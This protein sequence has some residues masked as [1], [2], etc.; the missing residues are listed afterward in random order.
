MPVWGI[1]LIAVGGVFLL[2][3][4]IVGIIIDIVLHKFLKREDF[5]EPTALMSYK[6]VPFVM[7]RKKYSFRSGRNKIAAFDYGMGNRKG[8]VIYVHGMCPGHQGYISDIIWLVNHGYEVFT[9]DFTGTGDS[10]G[11]HINGITQQ[12]K[13][14]K[15]CL[16]FLKTQEEFKD[17]KILLYGHSMGAYG[18]AE[19]INASSQIAAVVSISGFN[20]PLQQILRTV[21]NEKG[22]FAMISLA[23]PLYLVSFFHLGFSHDASS[24]HQISKSRK[25]V[26]VVHGVKDEDVDFNHGSIIAYRGKIKNPNVEYVIVSDP[27]HYGHLSILASTACVDYQNR[28]K[29]QYAELLK[30]YNGDKNQ[31]MTELFKDFDKAKANEA[32]DV[33]MEKTDKFFQ[34][35][36]NN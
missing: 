18:V 19:D 20:R 2:Y 26:M 15:A 3:L 25:P 24:V 6:E 36:L 29:A 12:A 9:Y 32:N 21:K 23:L 17:R 33:L 5:I 14:L 11:R 4:L 8:F 31:A 7:P 22:T 28:K 13:D 34:K 30:Q 27:K 1:V 10:E 16:R 35:S